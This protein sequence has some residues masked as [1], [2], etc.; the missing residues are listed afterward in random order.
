V[1]T[2]AARVVRW[3]TLPEGEA[4]GPEGGRL[5]RSRFFYDIQDGLQSRLRY[6]LRLLFAPNLG[7]WSFV[8][9]PVRLTFLYAFLRP[10]RFLFGLAPRVAAKT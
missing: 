2:L 10:D 9:L 7:D 3:W 1:K 8:R 5:E 4:P 6:L